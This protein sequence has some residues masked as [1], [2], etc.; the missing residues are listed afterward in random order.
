MITAVGQAPSGEN[1]GRFQG[2]VQ[3]Y[4]E[5]SMGVIIHGNE[6]AYGTALRGVSTRDLIAQV[7]DSISGK[8]RFASTFRACRSSFIG[9][10]TAGLSL[11]Y[12][13]IKAARLVQQFL[14][15]FKQID[16]IRQ[17]QIRKIVPTL[18]KRL[19]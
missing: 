9:V 11:P 17:R 5:E 19:V 6:W 16:M 18:V 1:H 2:M 15:G 13:S 7:S 10:M 4:P 12:C 14:C 8:L 3:L